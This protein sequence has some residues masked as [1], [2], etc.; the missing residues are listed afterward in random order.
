MNNNY[1][2][3]VKIQKLFFIKKRY[4]MNIKALFFDI[5]GTLVSFKTHKIQSST[6]EALQKA[7]EK[8]IKIYISTGRPLG[9]ITNL[10]EIE[11]LIDGYITT[12][13]AFSFTKNSVI[14]KHPMNTEEVLLFIDYAKKYDFCSIV[15]GTKHIAVINAKEV[16]ERIF[17]QGLH[18]TTFDLS[19]PVSK[20]LEDEVLQ[21]T[22]FIPQSLQ[23]KIMP[24]LPHC[25]ATRWHPEFIDVS[26]IEATKGKALKEV[27]MFENISLDN[28][29]A[30][31]DGEN[32]ISIL[33][34]SGIGVAMGNA[35]D[36][37]KAHANYVTSSV[38]DNG[39]A[40]ALQHFNVI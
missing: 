2:Q 30:F 24:S 13:G 15:I 37:V 18:I 17:V 28:I 1:Q 9:F 21:I 5:D 14:S 36:N 7:K 35:S 16:L 31:G 19:I 34:N 22:P 4:T 23:D 38:D 6:I 8:G 10:S 11:H 40:K 26:H 27:A 32:D 25:I 20:V 39:I 12:N 3:Q 33:V 29:M